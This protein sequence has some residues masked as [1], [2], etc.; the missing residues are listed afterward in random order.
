MTSSNA[1]VWHT[2]HILLNNLGGK[3]SLVM[4]FGQFMQYYKKKNFIKKFFEKCGLETS[5]RLFL[6]FKESSV[7][8]IL[9]RSAWWF[10]QIL[11]DLLLHI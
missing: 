3:R 4:K 5:S 2:K 8:K 11:T 9:W 10:G 1:Q 7:K 6:I